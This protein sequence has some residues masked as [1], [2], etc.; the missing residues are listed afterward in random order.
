MYVEVMPSEK[1]RK[2]MVSKLVTKPCRQTT[3]KLV[4]SQNLTVTAIHLKQL[5]RTNGSRAG[6]FN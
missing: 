1:I 6:G 5:I 4:M 3:I 2:C